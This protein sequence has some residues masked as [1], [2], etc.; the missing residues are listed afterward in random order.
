[1][2]Q[3]RG[4]GVD[5]I[6]VRTA[7]CPSPIGPLQ[8]YGWSV[9]LLAVALPGQDRAAVERRLFGRLA[10]RGRP[11]VT[12][13]RDEASLADACRQLA[14]YFAGRRRWFDVP[15]DPRGTPFQ[16]Q[17][18]EQVRRIPYGTTWSYRRLAAAT[19]QPEAVRAVAAALAANPLPIVIPCHRVIGAR[20]EL[21]GY[22]AGLA[23]K[24]W[25]LAHERAT[26][27]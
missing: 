22:A 13:E 11:P 9:G 25:L 2:T 21:R 14:E 15:L 10:G 24:A 8:L 3:E 6:V 16:L 27:G 7:E 12:L 4:R 23:L 19:R 18:W 5:R 17:V 26:A 1:M 20:G